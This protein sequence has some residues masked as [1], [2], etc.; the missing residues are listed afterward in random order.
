MDQDIKDLYGRKLGATDGAI[1]H[2]KDF[3]F[4]DK[5]WHLRY[6]VAD[7]GSWLS[8]RQVLL[9]PHAF[10]PHAFGPPEADPDVVPVNLTRRQ[11]E[12]SP[13]IDSHRP[14]SRQYEEDYHRYFGWPSYWVAG[15]MGSVTGFTPVVVPPMPPLPP[16]GE[17]HPKEDLHLRSTKEVTGYHLQA[18]DGKL[19]AIRSF[20]VD[21]K[22]WA[23]PELVVETGHWYAGK[24][25]LILTE[26]IRRISYEDKTVFVS[27]DTEDIRKTMGNAVAKR[28][29]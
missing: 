5:T 1:G 18:T 2:I 19:G 6:V 27:F 9:S 7:T 28:P 25:I 4:D 29:A 23:I 12:D 15:G 22:T 24:P 16:P 26:T 10:G 20:M 21:G 13:S 17:R 3:Y 14:I 11:I 8:G